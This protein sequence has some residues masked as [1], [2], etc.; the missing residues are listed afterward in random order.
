[1][2]GFMKDLGLDASK[3]YSPWSKNDMLRI[4]RKTKRSYR[5]KL[6]KQFFVTL[7]NKIIQVFPAK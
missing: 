6:L 7:R 5:K 1:M 2:K 3:P 4:Y